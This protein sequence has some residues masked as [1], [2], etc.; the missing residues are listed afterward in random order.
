MATIKLDDIP[1][2]AEIIREE[3]KGILGGIYLP[4]YDQIA[5]K[6]SGV[7]EIGGVE[8]TDTWSGE[9]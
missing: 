5:F 4:K 9:A 1:R 2:E 8:H 3:L 7:Y 6:C